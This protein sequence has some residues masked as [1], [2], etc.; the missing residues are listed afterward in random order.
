[1][2]RVARAMDE[3]DVD[4][5]VL[6]PGASMFY[7][8]GFEHGHAAERLLALV[9]RRDGST[10]WIVPAMNVP[11]V[12]AHAPDGHSIR[13]WTDAET[14]LPAL[15]DA[16]K[17]ARTIAFDDEARAAFLMDLTSISPQARLV[18]ASSI[19][20]P[21]RARKDADELSRL[22]A[23]GKVVDD[24]I[25]LAVALCRPG[26]R[27]SD[28]ESDL[29]QALLARSPESSVAFTIVASGPNAALPHHET[30]R[31]LLHKGDVVILDFGIREPGGYHSDI[32][33]TCSVGE[34]ADPDVR[35]V[36]QVVHDAQRAAIDA[37]RPGI[38]CEEIDRAARA[39]IEN[40]GFGDR[41]L[42]RT[43]H[44]LGLQVHEPP[45]MVG[46]NRETLEQGMT[47]SIEPGIYLP[48]RFGVRLEIIT[49]VGPDGADLINAPSAAEILLARE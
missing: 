5:L 18:K 42:H 45:Y 22:R 25:P 49:A 8:S 26:R 13:A 10:S 34:P 38:P 32:T 9:V 30:S 3:R 28:V 43:G 35:R 46:G 39:V 19:L 44:G 16:V 7:L 27:E 47:F 40:A 23:A 37:V 21:L 1:M 15:T 31:R 29:R 2:D 36:Y 6:T 24:T 20:R 17:G 33:V 11:Q 14:Y 48:E 4:T 41:F 12:E